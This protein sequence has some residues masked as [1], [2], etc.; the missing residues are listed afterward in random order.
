NSLIA[1]V[2]AINK[3]DLGEGFGTYEE[4]VRKIRCPVLLLNVDTDQEFPPRC[5]E[6][7]ARILNAE[8]PGQ[9]TV[10][11]LESA[12]G[13]LGCV[14]E[15]AQLESHIKTWMSGCGL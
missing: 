1:L 6:E 10:R 14:R 8:Q 9:A 7:L 5:A 3:Y 12:W 2:N 13:H 11:I 15:S 4:G